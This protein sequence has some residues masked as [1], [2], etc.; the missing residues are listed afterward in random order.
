[1]AVYLCKMAATMVAS[2]FYHKVICS[3][4]ADR[5]TNIVDS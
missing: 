4:D 3:K 1:M 5:M 2:R